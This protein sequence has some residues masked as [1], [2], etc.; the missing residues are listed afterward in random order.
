M[1]VGTES[2]EC[3]CTHFICFQWQIATFSRSFAWWRSFVGLLLW[4]LLSFHVHLFLSAHT[5]ALSLLNSCCFV[6]V[7]MYNNQ[8][9]ER[10]TSECKANHDASLLFCSHLERKECKKFCF[11]WIVIVCF[12]VVHMFSA[13]FQK[14]KV[15]GNW[16]S[17]T[18]MA[19][20]R[21][22]RKHCLGLVHPFNM[23]ILL[24]IDSNSIACVINTLT[25][26]Q[27]PRDGWQGHGAWGHSR[28]RSTMTKYAHVRVML[29]RWRFECDAAVSAQHSTPSYEFRTF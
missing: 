23:H 19:M 14:W 20:T 1:C 24:S 26:R 22:N 18:E 13:L 7:Q 6:V 8:T 21:V 25:R 2:W 28:T 17:L 27:C 16:M 4:M 5:H 29:W 12:G 9:N 10:E 3:F 15:N 11:P